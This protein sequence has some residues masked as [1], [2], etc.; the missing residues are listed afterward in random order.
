MWAAQFYKFKQ[1]R[2]FMTSGGLG[3]M[4]FGFPAAMGA[5]VARPDNIVIDIA[6]DGSIQMNIQEL[7]TVVP[8]TCP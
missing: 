1:P 6:G 5:Q 2:H 3:V 8:T 7:T 4:G